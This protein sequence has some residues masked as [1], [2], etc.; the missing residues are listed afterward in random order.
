MSTQISKN[1]INHFRACGSKYAIEDVDEAINWSIRHLLL[2]IIKMYMVGAR[3]DGYTASGNFIKSRHNIREYSVCVPI[4]DLIRWHFES[5]SRS[6]KYADIYLI[7]P[8][9]TLI[10]LTWR[11]PSNATPFTG[12]YLQIS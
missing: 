6:L 7:V 12:K 8:V 3:G 9:K 5:K 4:S 2:D 11:K 10:I 1:L